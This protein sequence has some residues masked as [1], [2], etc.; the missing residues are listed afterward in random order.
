[1]D[2]NFTTTDPSLGTTQLTDQMW[3]DVLGQLR[4]FVGRRV[5]DPER[6]EDLVG[7]ILLRIHQNLGSVDDRERLAHWSSLCMVSSSR[8]QASPRLTRH[9]GGCQRGSRPNSARSPA[10]CGCP[11]VTPTAPPADPAPRRWCR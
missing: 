6:A 9:G 4:A 5:A 10:G 7:E 11:G 3:R 1:M 2:T 8:P